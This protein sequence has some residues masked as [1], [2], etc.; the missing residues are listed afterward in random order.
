MPSPVGTVKRHMVHVT[1]LMKETQVYHSPT[2][3]F[4]GLVSK[5]DVI[6]NVN[7]SVRKRNSLNCSYS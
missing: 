7:L 1:G 4:S 5:S 2:S 3:A 6:I